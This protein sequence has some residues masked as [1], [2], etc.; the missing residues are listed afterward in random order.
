MRRKSNK[1]SKLKATAKDKRPSTKS[2]DTLWSERVK[3]R[4]GCKCEYCGK[5]YYLNAHHVFGRRHWG[6]RWD[7]DNGVALCP[8]H[9][10]FSPI[11]SAHQTPTKFSDWIQEK[12]GLLDWYFPLKRKSN[13][14]IK[15]S[16]LDLASIKET[17]EGK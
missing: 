17:L 4:A 7:L 16:E 9:H 13:Q 3:D 2:L 12:R 14:I 5:S 8:N 6:L 11:F 15:K 1:P 10:T